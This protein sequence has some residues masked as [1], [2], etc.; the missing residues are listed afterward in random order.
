[1]KVIPKK[2]T[3]FT[4]I[5]LLVVIAI[6]A[7]LIAL[8]LPAV[9]QARE[10]ARRS[11]CKNNLKQIGLALHNYHDTHRSFP[12]CYVD[13]V[14]G[15]VTSGNNLGWSMFLLPFQD[16]TPLYQKISETG[17]MNVFWTTVTPMTDSTTGYAKVIL[18]VFNCPSDPAGGINTKI[19]G[20]YG[21]SNYKALRSVLSY[22]AVTPVFHPDKRMLRD[23]TDGAS[24]TLI[25][26]ESDTQKHNGGLWVGKSTNSRDILSNANDTYRINGADV[27]DLFSSVHVGG[28]HFVFADGRV[29]FLSENISGE[30]YTGLGTYNGGEVLGEY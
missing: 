18:P 12:P 21:K 2:R 29:M 6:I 16:Q 10:A 27:D 15:G 28:C 20:S 13:Q 8:L 1:M 14:V 22:H 17:A 26:G 4:L 30:I 5:E 24:N 11:T 19:T 3:G 9:Q 7:I 23:F 25:V